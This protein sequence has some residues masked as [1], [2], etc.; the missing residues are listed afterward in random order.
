MYSRTKKSAPIFS[1]TRL[2]ASISSLGMVLTTVMRTWGTLNTAVEVNFKM[3]GKAC[4]PY[5]LWQMA[6]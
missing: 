4:S 6:S 3:A 5:W 2:Q 1:H